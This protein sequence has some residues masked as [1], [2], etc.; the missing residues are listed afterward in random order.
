MNLDNQ[1]KKKYLK[2]KTKYLNLKL[3][4]GGN[5]NKKKKIKDDQAELDALLAE[6][7]E[8]H[9]KELLHGKQ[10]PKI[11]YKPSF[12]NNIFEKHVNSINYTQKTISISFTDSINTILS[13]IEK[14]NKYFTGKILNIDE[15]AKIL[16]ISKSQLILNCIVDESEQFYSCNNRRLCMLKNLYL[17]GLFDGII[18]VNVVH[19]CSHDNDCI[20]DCKDVHINM[21]SSRGFK[22]SEL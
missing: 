13:N 2:Y 3:S 18:I 12:E 6:I 4:L 10:P 7:K 21:G 8:E 16:E 15:I 11:N 5:P 17:K 22:C 1:Y 14:I 19:S 20:Y 9:S